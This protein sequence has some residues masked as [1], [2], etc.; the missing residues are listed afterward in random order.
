MQHLLIFACRYNTQNCFTVA[1]DEHCLNVSDHTS[2]FWNKTC[3]PIKDYCDNF[4]FT[5]INE[6]HCANNTNSSIV[7]RY[8]DIGSRIG[9]SED[10]YT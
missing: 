8:S 1:E 7:M 10:Y 9:A 3:Y 5:L 6:T 4:K 2:M